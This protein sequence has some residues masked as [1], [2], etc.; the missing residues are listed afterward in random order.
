M[1]WIQRKIRIS[2][3]LIWNELHKHKKHTFKKV[4]IASSG[5]QFK[6]DTHVITHVLRTIRRAEDQ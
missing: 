2:V 4:G 6:H 3:Y 1:I 5:V